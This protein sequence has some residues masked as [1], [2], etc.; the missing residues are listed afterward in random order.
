[1]PTP[2]IGAHFHVDNPLK[3]AIAAGADAAQF[4]LGDPQDWKAPVIAGDP[5]E[6]GR[7]WAEAGIDVYIHSPYPVNLA[8]TNNRIRHPSR[9]IIKQQ[10]K[11]AASIGAKGLVVHGGHVTAKDDPQDGLLNWAK[12]VDQIPRPIPL[13]IENTAGGDGAMART[14]DNISRLWDVVGGAENIGFCLDTCHANSA[15]IELADAVEKIMAITGRI[16][17]VHCNNSRDE[18]D[19]GQDRHADLAKGTIDPA[20]LFGVVRTA[21]APAIC[22]TPGASSDVRFLRTNLSGALSKI[23][24]AGSSMPATRTTSRS[25]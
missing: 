24:P 16:D 4:F 23:P 17:L 14:L 19:S 20:L 22:E 15:G 18:F 3:E 25:G 2:R 9:T 12:A 13:L 21:N 11:A 7:A 5:A 10:L 6:V 8:S 1:M